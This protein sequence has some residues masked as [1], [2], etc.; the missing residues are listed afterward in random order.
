MLQIWFVDDMANNRHTWLMS[1]PKDLK[2]SHDFQTFD[3][4][5]QLFAAF[6]TGLMPDILFIDYY[7]GDR[8]GHE[9]VDYFRNH[10]QRPLLIAHS[11]ML[12]AN[13]VMLSRGADLIFEKKPGDTITR[14][15]SE[16]IQSEEDLFFLLEHQCG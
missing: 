1:F 5:E 6:H 8:R 7:I 10:T 11:S 15:I 13:R 12:D 3:T 16:N 2:N 14:S 9:V 4:V